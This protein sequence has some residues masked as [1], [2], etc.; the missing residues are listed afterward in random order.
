MY[1]I[2]LFC[3]LAIQLNPNNIPQVVAEMTTEEKVLLLIGDRKQK[4]TDAGDVGYTLRGVP[5]AAGMTY[6][7]PRLGIPAIILADGP[8]GLRI[9][10]TRQGDSNTYYCTGFPIGTMLSSTWNTELVGEVGAAMGN[11]VLEYGVDVLL[12]PGANI[13]RNPLCGRNFEYFSEDPVLSGE[14]AAAYINGVQSQG[15]GTSLKHF[16]LNNQEVN[17]LANNVVVSERAMNEIYLKAFE[18]A[19]KK[20]QPWTVM[21]SYNYINGV[22]A[23]ENKH[24]LTDVLRGEWGFA[25]A[26][27]TDWGGGYRSGAIIEAGN[28]MIQPGAKKHIEAITK[29]LENNSLSM[30]ALDEC[31]TRVLQLIVKTP[32]FRKYAFSSKPDLKAHAQT[33][34]KAAEEGIV[35]LKRGALPYSKNTSIALFGVGSYSFIAGGTGSGDVHKPY[36]LSL[37]EGLERSG[38]AL[39]KGTAEFYGAYMAKE[40]KRCAMID[41]Q[42]KPWYIDAERP[43]EVVPTK[44][45]ETASQSVQ[46]AIITIT[47]IAGEGKD[48]SIE[49]SYNLTR[50]ELQLIDKVSE[51]FH[52]QKKAVTVI[53][54]V[55]GVVDVTAWRDKVDDILVCWLPGQDGAVAVG[56]TL[57][58]E[59]N[60]SGRLPMTFTLSYWDVPSA[61]NFPI[62]LPDK[63]FNYSHYRNF[64]DGE[65]NSDIP[66]VDYT[67][68]AEDV[69]VGYRYFTTKHVKVAYP[70][71]YGLSYTTFNWG[72]T[73]VKRT[74][75]G[76]NV[77][78]EVTNTG[79][80]PGKD[81]VQV[82]A[83]GKSPDSP[84][85]ELKGFVKTKLLQSGQSQVVTIFVPSAD[86]PS[87]YR[88]VTLRNAQNK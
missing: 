29:A 16:A 82:Y 19:V 48:R 50:E 10:P 56:K 88:L 65:I 26:V 18:I 2:S 17:R 77:S 71:G 81:V 87:S 13:H 61:E 75:E 27:M 45:I 76:Y 40:R 70:F 60:P 78:V 74:P 20:S 63:P 84:S 1:L 58:G 37:D 55:C 5:G 59:V 38:F 68:Y 80:L 34:C 3:L 12:A 14:I 52:K 33:S 85:L 49:F 57:C 66:N 62:I 28:D 4:T 39:E 32:T 51:A 7:I 47:R 23:A 6:A 25:G 8:A 72:K 79:K 86:V 24:L 35:L 54:N 83:K 41:G 46:A 9:N 22:H 64:R 42:K 53:L 73:S 21:T 69:F 30:K 36:V 44:Q 67:N 11:E 31:V 43:I 15:V